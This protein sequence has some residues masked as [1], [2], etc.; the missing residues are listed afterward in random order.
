MDSKPQLLATLVLAHL[1]GAQ[2]PVGKEALD[3]ELEGGEGSTHDGH[4]WK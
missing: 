3:E 1:K 2:C 4:S